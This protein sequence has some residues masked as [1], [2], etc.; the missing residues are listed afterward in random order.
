MP[1]SDSCP[2]NTPAVAAAYAV[3]PYVAQA[4]DEISFQVL[5]QLD[6]KIPIYTSK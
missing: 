2:I 4:P 6:K 5:F 3:R 1:E